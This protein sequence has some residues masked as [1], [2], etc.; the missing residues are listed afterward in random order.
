MSML[1]RAVPVAVAVLLLASPALGQVSYGGHTVNANDA[2]GGSR[3]VGLRGQIGLPLLPISVAVNGEYFFTHCSDGDCGLYGATFDL[4]YSLAIPLL[5]PFV[6]LGW[7]VREVEV[8]GRKTTERGINVG[9]G[10]QFRLRGIRPFV[11][12][13]YELVDAPEKQ[14]VVRIGLL[15]R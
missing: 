3:G 2:F 4:N 12:I 6:G 13:R 1:R 7:S 14:F 8:A 9:V 11:D 5:Q 15:L 10:A